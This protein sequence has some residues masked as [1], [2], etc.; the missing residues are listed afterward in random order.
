M[1]R[2]YHRKTNR[3]DRTSTTA[4][5]WARDRVL[6]SNVSVRAAAAEFNIDR[7]TLKRF[8]LKKSSNPDASMGY[9]GHRQVLSA[10]QEDILEDYLLTA[11]KI[12][13]GMS[14]KSTR[15]LAYQCAISFG[16]S[17]PES[18]ERDKCAGTDWFQGFLKR[19][20]SLSLRTPEA[21]SLS[22]ATSFNKHNISTFFSNLGQVYER[23]GFAAKDVWNVDETGITT[24]QK[25][26]RI[27][28]G[29]GVKQV[30]AI[31][32][33]ERGTLVTVCGAINGAGNSMPP[34]LIF[35]RKTFKPHYI[36][37]GPNG[38]TGSSHKSGW[39]TSENFLKFIQHFVEH[40]KSSV[41]K[42]VLLLLDN[43]HSH[44]SID[45]L[46]FAKTHGVVMLSIPPHCSH[47][48]QPL[49]VSVYGALKR[50][51]ASAQ[52]A[53]LK[54]HP[55]TPMTIYDIPGILREVW[56]LALTP[57]N[58][59]SGF[60]TT[61]IFPLNVNVFNEDDFAPS[62][63]TDRSAPSSETAA[64]ICQD[65]SPVNTSQ[66]VVGIL[67]D[68]V[69]VSSCRADVDPPV[70]D[71]MV[72][73]TGE[74]ASTALIDVNTFLQ[75]KGKSQLQVA[76]DGHCLLHAFELAIQSELNIHVNSFQLCGGLIKEI[77]E[78]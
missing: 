40:T 19:H 3:A 67:T 4:L 2:T 14:P 65:K 25:P 21:T 24:V 33:A 42:P 15:E 51:V 18:W 9:R 48:L 49:D 53:W 34:M 66:P 35:P 74:S 61:G 62:Y 77:S 5:K 8:I 72:P 41:E 1:T 75:V 54:T 23:Y 13:F 46:T 73:N 22:R 43:H 36:R 11:S 30:G 27:V 28:A 47:K 59:I 50:L 32:S 56:P 45:I 31:T 10:Q 17:I 38:C 58:V 57:K 63:V 55:G 7:S 76:G 64:E 71:A 44:I 29:K 12:Y 39:M 37:D 68:P 70:N 78:M 6:L 60:Q 52:D 20:G 26:R 69:L 16:I